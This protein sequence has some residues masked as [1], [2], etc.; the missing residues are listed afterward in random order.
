[1]KPR[2]FLH[3]NLLL[4]FPRKEKLF[5]LWFN[6]K[7]I[8]FPLSRGSNSQLAILAIQNSNFLVIG[9]FVFIYLF[10]YLHLE[11][12]SGQRSSITFDNWAWP[13]IPHFFARCERRNRSIIE[14][15]E[16]FCE[17]WV[18]T[19]GQIDLA[20]ED[21]YLKGCSRLFLA[22]RIEATR[23]SLKEKNIPWQ[24]PGSL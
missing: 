5:P 9:V 22:T 10:L 18:S 12:A 23:L 16:A 20:A 6:L 17:A 2:I 8:K 19:I 11:L 1:M 14:K 15:E 4:G 3:L 24:C 7:C 21:T 13:M